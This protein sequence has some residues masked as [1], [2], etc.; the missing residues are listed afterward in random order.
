MMS[1][2]EVYRILEERL[3]GREDVLEMF[4]H[5]PRFHDY[6]PELDAY[7]SKIR[8]LQGLVREQVDMKLE[9]V[10]TDA[11]ER[12]QR[13]DTNWEAV[14]TEFENWGLGSPSKNMQF[15]LTGHM[16]VTVKH[17]KFKRAY[18]NRAKACLKRIKGRERTL[19]KLHTP[20]RSMHDD[21]I[22]YEHF[23]QRFGE[24]LY[25]ELSVIQEEREKAEE[26]KYRFESDADAARKGILSMPLVYALI[27]HLEQSC[28]LAR[29]HPGD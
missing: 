14:Q 12:K 10:E 16:W 2:T 13:F 6:Q 24:W 22:R 1:V 27:H 25:D 3:K 18:Q 26:Y 20:I 21:I 9:C 15:G 4:R 19:T 11:V 28:N 8:E 23:L 7:L 17:A 29:N 5:P